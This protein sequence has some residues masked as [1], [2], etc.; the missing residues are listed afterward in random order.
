MKNLVDYQTNTIEVQSSEFVTMSQ[1]VSTNTP[2]LENQIQATCIEKYIDQE[3]QVKIKHIVSTLLAIIL[4][5][6]LCTITGFLFFLAADKTSVFYDAIS[7]NNTQQIVI[8]LMMYC[9]SGVFILIACL[10]VILFL[11]ACAGCICIAMQDNN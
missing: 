3:L 6:S 10:L 2:D 7:D 9:I 1:I 8:L 11:S 5:L 4:A